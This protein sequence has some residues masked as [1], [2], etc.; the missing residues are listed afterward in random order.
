[1][2]RFLLIALIMGA[3]L[4]SFAQPGGRESKEVIEQLRIAF[5]TEELNLTSEEGQVFWPLFNEFN[6]RRK[7]MRSSVKKVERELGRK[8]VI[9]EEDILKISAAQAKALRA[10][11]DLVEEFTPKF[12][13]V[14]GPSRTARMIKAE[15][16]F[17]RRM[18]E[19]IEQRRGN[20]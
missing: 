17:K 7:A 14:L 10:E 20:R 8:D 18:L 16:K 1:M 19:R 4:A 12:L 13:D 3:S 5:I 9:T 6:D 15:E 11:A 2:K